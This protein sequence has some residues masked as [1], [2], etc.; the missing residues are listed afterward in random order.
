MSEIPEFQTVVVSKEG[1]FLSPTKNIGVIRLNRPDKLNS[2]N[3][4]MV[5]DLGDALDY[6]E[7][8]EDIRVVIITATGKAFSAGADLQLLGSLSPEESG[9]V[10]T[11]GHELF[12]KIENMSKA[13][14]A[15][16]QALALGGGC[17]LALAC[18]L[19]VLSSEAKIGLPEVSL[20]VI[21]AWGG[22]TR[23][24]RLIGVSRAKEVILTGTALTAKEA[25]TYGIANKVVDP[26]EL[27]STALFIATKIAGNAPVAIRYAKRG[28]G[29][30]L[31]KS[32]EESFAYERESFAECMK[33]ED[34]KEG[35]QAVFEKRKPSFSGK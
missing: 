9:E 20:G 32:Y 1:S 3:T 24:P 27:M 33:T 22:L 18:D 11:A 10:I 2:F 12:N 19:R 6:L 16:V 7:S 35:I 25:L 21:S 13:V 34:V 15:A 17:E 14:I 23:L 4:E 30:T 29:S 26:D 5:Q 8:S 28:A 31:Q